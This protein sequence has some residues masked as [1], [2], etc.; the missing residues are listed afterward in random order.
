MRAPLSLLAVAG[1]LFTHAEEGGVSPALQ[2]LVDTERAFAQSAV[3]K[4]IRDSFLEY[5]ADDAISITPAPKPAKPELQ[6]RP[7][8]PFSEL[9]LTWEPRTGDIAASGELGWLTGPSTFINHTASPPQPRYGNYLSIWRRQPAGQWR[10]LI[11][12]GCQVPEAAAFAPGFMP[13]A[14]PHRWTSGGGS[15]AAAETLTAAERSLNGALARGAAARAYA[16]VLADHARLHRQR[17]APS[18]GREAIVSRLEQQ[19]D[20]RTSAEST[21]THAADSGDLGYSYGRYD[22][23][24]TPAEHGAYLRVWSR[25]SSGRWWLMADVTEPDP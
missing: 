4:G 25:D 17:V 3:Q 10:V 20:A 11:D 9:E 24:R 1:L 7:S 18:V 8:R 5:F 19:G 14:L 13:L 16:V 15:V 23:A 22:V 21:A 12:I 6:S 2:A